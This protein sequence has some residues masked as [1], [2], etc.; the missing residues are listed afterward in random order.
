M[1]LLKVM[2]FHRLT[3]DLLCIHSSFSQMCTLQCDDFLRTVLVNVF[4]IEQ[5]FFPFFFKLAFFSVRSV[6][7]PGKNH[8]QTHLIILIVSIS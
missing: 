8:G 7:K 6:D 2:L 5:C 3:L 1:C 4:L